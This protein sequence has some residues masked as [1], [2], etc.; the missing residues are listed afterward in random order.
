MIKI[1]GLEKKYM[2]GKRPVPVLKDVDVQVNEGEFVMI[3]GESGSGKSTFLKCISTLAEP[4]SG[5]VSFEGHNLAHAKPQTIESIRLR[6]FGFIFQ[7]NH[8]IDGLTILENVIVSRLQYDVDA[9]AKGMA[10]LEQLNIAHLRDNFPHQVSGGEKQRAAI[11]RALV[12]EP[13]VLFA[14]EPT[15][16]LNPKTAEKIMEDLI[17]LNKQGQT[18]VMVTHSVRIAS[19]GTRLL[20]LADQTFQEDAFVEGQ[21]KEERREYVERLVRPYL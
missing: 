1:E 13:K 6:S 5:V 2:V 18:I 9:H 19:Y 16:S 15:A 7:E 10:L 3:M 4:T 20:V 12:N 21:S 17:A 11:A 8:M 14:D